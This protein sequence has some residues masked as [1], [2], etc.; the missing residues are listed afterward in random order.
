MEYQKRSIN[1]DA[2][3]YLLAYKMTRILGWPCR[4]YGV[5]LGV[6]AELEIMDSNNESTGDIIKVQIKAIEEVK[7]TGSVSIYVDDR[8]INYWK[9]FCLPV[10][11]CC[12][13]LNNEKV[14][15]KQITSTEA[16]ATKGESKKV[17]F[18]ITHDLLEPVSGNK[19]KE[20][21][22]PNDSKDIEPLFDNL[23][24]LY[25]HITDQD[26]G[27]FDEQAIYAMEY[28]CDEVDKVIARI[29][30]LISHFP[31]RLSTMALSQLRTIKRNV[32]ITRN[33]CGYQHNN[34]VNG[35]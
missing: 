26:G 15:W 18:C 29:E 13:D 4:L 24:N 32:Q 5:D 20:L 23:L 33:D 35:M 2:G 10:I 34:M 21:A 7:T 25:K 31:W 16:Y 3:E 14:Y 28:R 1:G 6:D 22:C 8:H 9:R 17:S 11:V 12:V 30:E 27:Y 19:L